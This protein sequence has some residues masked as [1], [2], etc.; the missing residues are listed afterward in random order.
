MLLANSQPTIC[1]VAIAPGQTYAQLAS[2]QKLAFPAN[3]ACAQRSNA[4]SPPHDVTAGW[5]FAVVGSR[6][7]C[8]VSIEKPSGL[9]PP[10]LCPA[11][12]R[13]PLLGF[14]LGAAL[15]CVSLWHRDTRNSVGV[16]FSPSARCSSLNIFL[17][18]SLSYLLCLKFG[19][20]PPKSVRRG[21]IPNRDRSAP[22]RL[23]FS[24]ISGHLVSQALE[25]F[26]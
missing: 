23:T 12:W 25:G 20:S 22:S 5:I 13:A 8:L 21:L 26:P 19:R 10:R 3:S 9:L 24:S 2:F 18:F 1:F 17:F 4:Y 11:R 16:F 6:K 15:S 14:R 7:W